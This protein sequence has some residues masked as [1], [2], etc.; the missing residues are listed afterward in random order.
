LNALKSDSAPAP[1]AKLEYGNGIKLAF[2]PHALSSFQYFYRGIVKNV[3]Y[4][5]ERYQNSLENVDY[6]YRVIEAGLHPPYWW[7]ADIDNSSYYLESLPDCDTNSVL[8]SDESYGENMLFGKQW[9]K[10]KYEITPEI[11]PDTQESLALKRINE[12]KMKYARKVT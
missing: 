4:F 6:I 3:G 12:I 7:F 9:F 1:R 8:R 2:Y 5:D 10:G 11:V